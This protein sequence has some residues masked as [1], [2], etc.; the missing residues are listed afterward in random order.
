MNKRDM[1]RAGYD[2]A[3]EAHAQSDR[4]LLTLAIVDVARTIEA[5]YRK[6]DPSPVQI[7]K[8]AALTEMWGRE[9][10]TGVDAR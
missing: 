5:D 10:E 3:T 9:D 8:M 2:K 4:D 7:G 1:F 6:G